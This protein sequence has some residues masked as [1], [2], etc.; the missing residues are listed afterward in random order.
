MA[1]ST[2]HLELGSRT[3]KHSEVQG[4][5]NPELFWEQSGIKKTT[6]NLVLINV[7]HF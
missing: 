6:K 1:R 2:P 4:I 3:V 5:I 7:N